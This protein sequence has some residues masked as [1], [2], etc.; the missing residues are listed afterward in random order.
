MGAASVVVEVDAIGVS[1]WLP[2]GLGS[3]VAVDSDVH[4]G[5]VRFIDGK[6]GLGLG[7][8]LGPV[9]VDHNNGNIMGGSAGGQDSKS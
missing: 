8:S 9:E 7:P 3:R 6:H 5:D 1:Q 4:G 2:R